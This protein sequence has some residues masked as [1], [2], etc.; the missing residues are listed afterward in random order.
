MDH[1]YLPAENEYNKMASLL[2]RVFTAFSPPTVEKKS[3]AIRFGI[4]GAART[5]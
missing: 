4:L 3:D 2:F 1:I 5:A